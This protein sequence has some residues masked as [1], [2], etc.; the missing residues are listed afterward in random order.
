MKINLLARKYFC[1][2]LN[3][4]NLAPPFWLKNFQYF[5]AV[6]YHY[7]C[8]NIISDPTLE[9]D[10]LILDEHL[11]FI[12]SNM[13]VINPKSFD[14]KTF[15]YS[16]ENKPSILITVD[17]A[18][19][20]IL[21][22]LDIFEKYEIPIIIFV[23]FGL[24][25]DSSTRDGLRS[26]ILRSFFEIKENQEKAERGI[27]INFFEKIMS[28][29]F[30]ELEEIYFKINSKRN[31][32]DIISSRTLLNFDEL[33]KLS[34]HPLITISSHSMS[35]PVL[36]KLPQKWLKWEIT[37]SMQYLRYVNGD[38]KY[39]AYPYGY[40]GSTNREVKE[41]LK[42]NGVKYA[43]STRSKTVKINSD[44]LE[45]GR[46]GMLGF[47]NKSYFRGLAG[48]AFEVFDALLGR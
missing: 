33:E 35:H 8:D 10:R 32:K 48:G 47:F 42:K 18:D 43:F 29:S 13:N 44:L 17:D 2:A 26:R 22:S 39:F 15:F 1:I 14:H 24:C 25:L 19:S 21:K 46:V 34:H 30:E 11:E 23:P 3:L 36:T 5:V 38:K 40:K 27:K 12:S 16:E 6:D 41:L 4:L 45:L 31:N 7:F 20:S 37:C 9:V 28:S